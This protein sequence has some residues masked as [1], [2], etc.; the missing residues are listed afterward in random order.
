SPPWPRVFIAVLTND[1]L[2][3]FLTPEAAAGSS[4]VA[5]ANLFGAE[6]GR[7]LV[8]G[9]VALLRALAAE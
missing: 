6:A 3:Y 1:Y 2:G 5:C 4:Y 8:S 9:A 7:R